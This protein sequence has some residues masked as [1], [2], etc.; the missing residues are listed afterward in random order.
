MDLLR[1]LIAFCTL[2]HQLLPAAAFNYSAESSTLMRLPERHTYTKVLQT[3]SSGRATTATANGVRRAGIDS[4]LHK[5][6]VQRLLS[7][8]FHTGVAYNVSLPPSLQGV[9]CQVMRLR[10]GSLHRR[11]LSFN[12]FL[13]PKGARVHTGGPFVL[14]VYKSI[15]LSLTAL[16]YTLPPG[17]TLISPILGLLVYTSLTPTAFNASSVEKSLTDMPPISITI[18]IDE[19]S[20]HS[21]DGPL[22]AFFDI[23]GVLSL[24]SLSSPPST[25]SSATLMDMALVLSSSSSSP[26]PPSNYTSNGPPSSKPRKAAPAKAWRVALIAV[27]ASFCGLAVMGATIMVGFRVLHKRHVAKMVKEPTD[28][29]ETLQTSVIGHTRAPTAA[30]VRTKPTLETESLKT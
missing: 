25:C 29:Q 1:T 30:S 5:Y 10:A 19:S 15:P 17:Y 13:I 27:L 11:G 22:C 24:S 3:H 23:N 14:M 2:L 18:P 26:P 12:D 6:A 9:R 28:Q 16:L 20:V 21:Q 4:N 8:H 7:G